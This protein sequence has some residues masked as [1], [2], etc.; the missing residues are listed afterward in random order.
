MSMYE[1]DSLIMLIKDKEKLKD[2]LQ[3]KENSIYWINYLNFQSMIN[4]EYVD[5]DKISNLLNREYP[6]KIPEIKE[7]KSQLILELLI[8]DKYNEIIKLNREISISK[9]EVIAFFCLYYMLI[10]STDFNLK[11][12]RELKNISSKKIELIVGRNK[13]Q[14]NLVEDNIILSNKL[15]EGLA[16]V[17]DLSNLNKSIRNYYINKQRYL[18]EGFKHILEGYYKEICVIL[19]YFYY[20]K[21]FAY[22]YA[23]PIGQ[24]F[25]QYI[26][27]SKIPALFNELKNRKFVIIRNAVSHHSIYQ[28]RVH[29]DFTNGKYYFK[30]K[31]ESLTLKSTELAELLNIIPKF[32]VSIN[33]AVSLFQMLSFNENKSLRDF[34]I[35]LQ[36]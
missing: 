6:D 21:E 33:S 20:E 17:C 16:L 30:D 27:K 23:L 19:A 18:I 32:Q 7:F 13:N 25:D 11:V 14:I 28:E 22:F 29:I 1:K 35:L 12:Y 34:D 10:I 3:N 24:L 9:Q 2:F 36:D 5:N 26:N 8:S 15:K 31:K 4:S